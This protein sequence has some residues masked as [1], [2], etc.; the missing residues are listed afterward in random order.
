MSGLPCCLLCC[1][2]K[3]EIL[4]SLVLPA[5]LPATPLFQMDIGMHG[6]VAGYWMGRMLQTF[7]VCTPFQMNWNPTISGGRCASYNVAFVTIGIL[8]M[9]TDPHCAFIRL[10]LS[11]DTDG[12]RNRDWSR[13]YLYIGLLRVLDHDEL[14]SNLASPAASPRE[15]LF[16]ST[17]S[18]NHAAFWS[19]AEPAVAINK[20]CIATLCPLLK[21]VSPL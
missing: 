9:I 17:Y 4:I 20:C 21:L 13:C 5:H 1:H 15:P 19:V 8:N 11:Q 2:D 12:I 16:A 7:L 6:L 3:Y 18:M 10:F 14:H